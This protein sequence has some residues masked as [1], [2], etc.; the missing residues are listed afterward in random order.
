MILEDKNMCGRFYVDKDKLVSW[1]LEKLTKTFDQ[2]QLDLLP[3]GDTRPNDCSI[4]YSNKN[5][6]IMKWG[7]E[8]FD[9]VTINTRVESISEK[10]YYIKDF[11]DNKCVILANGFYE[12]DEFGQK[13]YIHSN[14]EYL[15]LAG[16]Y[17]Y[18]EPFNRYSIITKPATTTASIHH[19]VPI[20]VP[21]EL[22][23]DYLQGK[24]SI[25][26]LKKIEIDLEIDCQFEEMQL[27]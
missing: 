16:I 1:V 5:Y 13:H 3:E 18:G 8:L 17:Q 23:P 4:V 9:H 26:D 15:F 12:W 24:I 10:D 11:K 6:T 20:L 2:K 21:R 19:R 14:S 25:E 22:V 7:Y 27:F